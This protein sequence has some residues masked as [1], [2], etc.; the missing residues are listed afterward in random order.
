[1]QSAFQNRYYQDEAVFSIFDYFQSGKTGNP[2]V[3][4]PTG[5]GK[6]VVIADFIRRVFS[7][8]P[9]QRLMMLTHV[10]KLI[11]QNASKL[12]AMW[13]N[14]PLGMHSAGLNKREVA[15]PIIYGGV[16]SVA[17]TIKAGVEIGLNP[18]GWRDLLLI[19]EA[20]LLSPEED[21]QYQFVISELRKIN[22][23]L[24]VIGFTA[25]GFRLKQG[26]LT[27]EGGIFSDVCYD[28]TGVE[29]FNKLIAEGYLAP[30]VSRPTCAKVDTA[31]LKLVAGEFVG[32]QVEDAAEKIAYE[33]LKETLEYGYNRN[34]WLVFAAG[35]KNAESCA[36]ILNSFG[37]PAVASHSKLSNKENES[38]MNAFE[39]GEYRALVGMNKYTTGYDF[40]AIDLIVDLQATNSPGKH[41]QKGG[42]GTRPSPQ[43]GKRDC[44]F[45]DF[46]GNVARLG[47]INDPVM[48]R[49]PGKGPPQ[50]APVRICP[51]C[52]VYNHASAR[53]CLCCNAEFKFEPKIFA[54][55]FE[56]EILKLENPVI[57]LFDVQKV[58]Y[59]LYKKTTDEGALISPPS[60]KV[61]YFCGFKM[62][63]EWV[64]L[65]HP[66]IV[67]KR[68]RDW[69]MQRH[70]EDPPVTTH[71][72]LQKVSQLRVPARIRV[73][74]DKKYP[75]ILNAEW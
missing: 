47:P 27:D 13:P 12:L 20:H 29:S 19:D 50:P 72:A 15:Q 44:L 3:L 31:S 17:P 55:S 64:C 48:P 74:T 26:K 4:M 11:S 18:F 6:S 28:I 58:I 16:Q 67:G 61:S 49:K 56:G 54:S 51:E 35:I 33:A 70:K 10:H 24:K 8:W 43:T 1:M 42:R 38:R 9:G 69:W 40:P 22:P 60:I 46:A 34:H 32:K 41:V 52:G 30:L 53:F 5:T 39:R 23:N 57:E 7:M 14:A 75:E 65:E 59:N 68:A 66:G 36:E 21:T 71:E 37:V 63:H 25:T 73:R 62:F 2:L 45:L